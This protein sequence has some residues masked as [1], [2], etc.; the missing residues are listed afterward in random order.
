M[1]DVLAR[2]SPEQIAA[3]DDLVFHLL[4]VIG[5]FVVFL[6]GLWQYRIA[7]A[8]K[9]SEWSQSSQVPAVRGGR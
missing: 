2:M 9:R 8:W 1:F 3:L 6:A 5:G 7:Q 4:T